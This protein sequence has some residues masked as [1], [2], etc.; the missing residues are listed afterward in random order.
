MQPQTEPTQHALQRPD[1]FAQLLLRWFDAHGR[2]DLPWQHPRSP[3]LVWLAEIML[4]QTQVATVKDYFRRF[5]ARFPTLLSLA[6]APLDEVLALWAGLGYYSRARNLHACAKRC[7]QEFAGEL[8][9][10]LTQLASLPG[11][12]RS[13]AAAILSQAYGVPAAILDGNV[14]RVL[15]RIFG[16]YGLPSEAAT[17]RQLWHLAQALLPKVRAADYTQALM[18]FGAT[19]CRARKPECANCPFGE[20]CIAFARDEIATLPR[21]KTPLMRPTRRQHWLLIREHSSGAYLLQR[22]PELGIWGGLYSFPEADTA[23][24]FHRQALPVND[25]KLGHELAEISHVFSHF[26][27]IA[28]PVLASATERSRVAEANWLWLKPE[29]WQNVGMPAP[30]AKLFATLG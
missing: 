10:D 12:G 9:A 11:I 29:Q 16:I 13:T 22:R 26:T 24:E 27:L 21:R 25:L 5:T 18:D 23:S 28:V 4:Q 17:E 7:V 14:K 15:C 19:H 3:Y 30:V 2:H 6:Q 20:H 8:P 1:R